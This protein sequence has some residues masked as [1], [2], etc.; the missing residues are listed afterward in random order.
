MSYVDLEHQVDER[1]EDLK[2]STNDD[3]LDLEQ[4]EKMLSADE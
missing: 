1:K 3:I 2:C 4:F